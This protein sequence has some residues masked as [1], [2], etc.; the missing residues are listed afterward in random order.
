MAS[1][2]LVRFIGRLSCWI[3][4]WASFT[5]PAAPSKRH[6]RQQ[7][8][9]EGE[10]QCARRSRVEPAS[11]FPAVPF[12]EAWRAE[13]SKRGRRPCASIETAAACDALIGQAAD[14]VGQ[15]AGFWAGPV[16]LARR[17]LVSWS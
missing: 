9:G 7:G 14:R 17:A 2:H 3:L 4:R 12:I 6:A 5:V 11:A 1:S 15:Y 13:Q 16:L 10:C 8:T